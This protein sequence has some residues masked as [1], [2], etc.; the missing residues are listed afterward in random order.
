MLGGE[1]G[2]CRGY[3][4]RRP[5]SMGSPSPSKSWITRQRR[6][7]DVVTIAVA[8]LSAVAT[9][10]TFFAYL[11]SVRRSDLVAAREEALALA[12]TRRQT[13][14]ELRERLTFVEERPKRVRAHSERRMRELPAAL[15]RPAA[16]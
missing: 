12:E 16:Q 2:L 6:M 9:A 3:L 1:R 8:A 7:S 14:R 13:I 10:G 4:R 15:D 5:R 11:Y